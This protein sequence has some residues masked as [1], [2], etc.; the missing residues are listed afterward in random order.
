[1]D[2]WVDRWMGGWMGGEMNAC[3]IPG[4]CYL[5]S[6]IFFYAPILW[7][8][9]QEMLAKTPKMVCPPL[10]LPDTRLKMYPASNLKNLRI[11]CL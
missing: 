11:I 1:M 10:S 5:C 7:G 6:N 4:P 2:G 8:R 9:E 3:K